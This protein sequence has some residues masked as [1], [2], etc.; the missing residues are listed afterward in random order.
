MAQTMNNKILLIGILVA[1]LALIGVVSALLIVQMRQP[2]AAA[3]TGAPDA[4]A[5]AGDAGTEAAPAELPAAAFYHELHPPFVVNVDDDGRGRYLQVDVAVMARSQKAVD[6]V[7]EHAPALRH[8]LNILFSSQEVA[9]LRT[10][11]GK[12]ALRQAALETIRKVMIEKTG[13]PMVEDVY[14]NKFV[15][16]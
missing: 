10:A 15:I 6:A 1:L 5:P 11:E 12:E 13:E 4:A 3:A 8:H 9:P 2:A 16:Q 7:K 14:F